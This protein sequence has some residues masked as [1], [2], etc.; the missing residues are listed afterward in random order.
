VNLAHFALHY[1]ELASDFSANY[2]AFGE[3]HFLVSG[4]SFV[5]AR[6]IRLPCLKYT[7]GFDCGNT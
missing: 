7:I 3:R 4:L 5:L 6:V 1:Y 2:L